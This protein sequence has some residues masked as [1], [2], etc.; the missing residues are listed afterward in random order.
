MCRNA[1]VHF[2]S[3]SCLTT[4]EK[5]EPFSLLVLIMIAVSMTLV[6]V[7]C[8]QLSI[9]II[10]STYSCFRFFPAYWVMPL[11]SPSIH[12]KLRIF[13]LYIVLFPSHFF[14]LNKWHQNKTQTLLQNSTMHLSNTYNTMSTFPGFYSLILI[15]SICLLSLSN[16]F[17]P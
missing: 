17:I 11:D 15:D 1:F 8:Y 5:L 14:C 13:I 12:I 10:Y 6:A 3:S 9:C 4:F 2:G 16:A 7:G